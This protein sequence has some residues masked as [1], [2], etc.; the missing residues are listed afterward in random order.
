MAEKR[1]EEFFP[2][3]GVQP[4]PH[5]REVF[6]LIEKARRD[7]PAAKFVILRAPT[8]TGKSAITMTLAQA[9]G[10]A[11]V[12]ASHR[13]L[14]QQYV[15]DYSH[16]NLGNLWGKRNY[17]CMA[18]ATLIDAPGSSTP[19]T[20]GDCLAYRNDRRVDLALS[21]SNFIAKHCSVHN[22]DG[23]NCPYQRAKTETQ[24]ADIALTNFNSFFAHYNYS[25][26][27][28]PRQALIIDEAHLL[29]GRLVDILS[30]GVQYLSRSK[31]KE[32]YPLPRP[33][34][35]M[36]QCAAWL[37]AKV[38]P[39]LMKTVSRVG[40]II[41]RWNSTASQWEMPDGSC[42]ADYIDGLRGAVQRI[43]ADLLK[44]SPTLA[45][46]QGGLLSSAHAE[47][48]QF[49][50]CKL[51]LTVLRLI[52]SLKA[53][54]DSWCVDVEHNPDRV[55]FRPIKPGRLAHATLFSAGSEVVLLSATLDKGP[56]LEDLG[57]R[58]DEIRAFIDVPSLF[59]VKCRPI[60]YCAAGNM[61]KADAEATLPKMAEKIAEIL[62]VNHSTH[63]G[64]IHTHTFKN[65]EMLRALLP[66]EVANRIIWHQ[67]GGPNVERLIEDFYD[68]DQMWLASPSCTEGLDGR[69]PR[70]RAQILMKAP[71]PNLGG[72]ARIKKRMKLPDGNLW[73]AMQAANTLIQA[74]GRGCRYQ[75]D[76]C[77]TYVLDSGIT[78][79]VGKARNNLPTWFLQAWDMRY[80]QRWQQNRPGVW[81]IRKA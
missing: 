31:H 77:V 1:L 42:A 12:L 16:L 56:F 19:Y 34:D 81:T 57:I 33:T 58:E 43:M 76:Y 9:A 62:T 61:R 73:Y 27:L 74:Y 10:T 15:D 2:L 24:A 59:P 7:K 29:P 26:L 55:V 60:I 17:V 72:S 30:V 39:F 5:Q 51:L 54:P 14:Q 78:G 22:G 66:P 68:S 18:S 67:P 11:H 4:Y 47:E 3:A 75:K 46:A 50:A 23:M 28:K 21:P 20:C 52:P 35:R 37:E 13:F 80:P 48:R 79:L 8:G 71:Y 64:I 69:G 65:G 53:H 63:K 36:E 40:P 32:V 45:G 6:S 44:A 70:V 38:L 25:G 49:R 41:V